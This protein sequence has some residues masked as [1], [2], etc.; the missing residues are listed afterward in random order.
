MGAARLRRRI[1][2]T[3]NKT[4][5]CQ[6]KKSKEE[7][8]E[9]EEEEEFLEQGLVLKRKEATPLHEGVSVPRISTV[10]EYRYTQK[11]A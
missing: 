2:S 11:S 5:A 8:E 1:Q 3:Q 10:T 7:G 9:G 6:S 4:R